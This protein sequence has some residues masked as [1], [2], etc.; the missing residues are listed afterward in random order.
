M[1]PIIHDN[2]PFTVLVTRTISWGISEA[3]QGLADV[4]IVRHVVLKLEG[5]QRALRET[6]VRSK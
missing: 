2:Q 5:R 6:Q 1:Y 3:T 4:C